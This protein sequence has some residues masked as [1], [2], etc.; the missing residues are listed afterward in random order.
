M[1]G[2][3]APVP[4]V[5]VGSL[6]TTSLLWRWGG[7]CHVTVAAKATFGLEH[8]SV[9]TTVAPAPVADLDVVP[10]RDQIDVVIVAAHAYSQRPTEATAVR[11]ALVGQTPVFDKSLLVY[12]PRPGGVVAPF[13]QAAIVKRGGRPHALVIDPTRPNERGTFGR[14]EG[15][16]PTLADGGDGFLDIE[17]EVDWKSF[18][19]APPDQRIAELAGDEWIVLEGMH[20][21]RARLTAKLPGPLVE[22]RIYGPELWAGHCLPL[23]MHP[24]VLAVNVDERVCSIVWRGSFTLENAATAQKLTVVSALHM[25]GRVTRWPATGDVAMSEEVLARR[26][27]LTAL[28]H[29]EHEDIEDEEARAAIDRAAKERELEQKVAAR[30]EALGPAASMVVDVGSPAD[31]LA[32]PTPRRTLLV[33]QVENRVALRTEQAPEE[34]TNAH[35]TVDLPPDRGELAPP[36]TQVAH[37]APIAGAP[38][39][40]KAAIPDATRRA[41]GGT[42]IAEDASPPDLDE[43]DLPTLE[44][45]LTDSLDEMSD[46]PIAD[47]FNVAKKG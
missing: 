47:L 18:N 29:T 31:T 25:P 26:A 20:P 6:A 21:D 7:A 2:P 35:G 16:L 9:M 19:L 38:W 46:D 44:Q 17:D 42:I 27:R 36:S 30:L 15:M 33:R 12:A 3:A 43:Q 34:T 40:R 32:A 24:C 22:S 5:P 4:V 13:Q 39:A 23:A 10:Y 41:A 14:T 28:A 37:L 1:S 45:T 8:R 11:F